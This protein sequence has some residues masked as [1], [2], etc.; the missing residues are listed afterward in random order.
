MAKNIFYSTLKSLGLN[1][2]F[3]ET[4]LQELIVGPMRKIHIVASVDRCSSLLKRSIKTRNLVY[5]CIVTNHHT[6]EAEIA[7]KNIG[8]YLMISYTVSTMYSVITRHQRFA[9]S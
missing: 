4:F 9:S 7:T 2:T 1:H 6:I 3:I 5:G 8:Q